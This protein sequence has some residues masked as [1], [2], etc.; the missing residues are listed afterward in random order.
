MLRAIISD[1]SSE[2]TWILQGRLCRRWAAEL[3]E[4]W[5]STR[6]TR[7]GR[8]CSVDLEDVSSV[9]EEGESVLLEMLLE[10]AVLMAHSAYMKDVVE[11]LKARKG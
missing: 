5:E 9:D 4:K 1:M 11:A 10:G 7:V 2:Q 6:S 3:K 8:T